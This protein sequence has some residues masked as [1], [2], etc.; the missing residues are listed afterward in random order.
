MPYLFN[1]LGPTLLTYFKYIINYSISRPR[2]KY[3]FATTFNQNSA[4]LGIKTSKE[5]QLI[6]S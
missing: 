2:P 6:V 4:A 1:L 3:G 5:L